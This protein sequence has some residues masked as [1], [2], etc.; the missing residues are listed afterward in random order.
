V[1]VAAR[2]WPLPAPATATAVGT[3][4]ARQPHGEARLL[5]TLKLC[6][7]AFAFGAWGLGWCV[8]V[9]VVT[10]VVVGASCVVVVAAAAILHLRR[11][12]GRATCNPIPQGRGLVVPHH[13]RAGSSESLPSTTRLFSASVGSP[14]MGS[15]DAS[16]RTSAGQPESAGAGSSRAR[17]KGR[18]RRGGKLKRRVEREGVVGGTVMPR[19]GPTTGPG[20]AVVGVVASSPTPTQPPSRRGA[21]R[22][23][24]VTDGH[25]R[26]AS[27]L[28]P[29]ESG[30]S[31]AL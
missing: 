10:V 25:V 31:S 21:Q 11:S 2:P 12:R 7:C 28:V 17:P 24:T 23:L 14:S 26:V 16:A 18:H 29:S 1:A 6:V 5:F 30:P 22:S 19:A 27:I 9:R 3:P 13:G 4:L 20:N 8:E 15:P